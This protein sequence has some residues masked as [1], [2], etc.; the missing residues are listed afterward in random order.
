[1]RFVKLGF[2][3]ILDGADHLLFLFCLVIPFRRL[4]PLI[5]IVTAFTVAHSISLS[6]AVAGF[7]PTGLWFPPLIELLIAA[8]IFYVAIENIVRPDVR[9]RYALW[10]KQPNAKGTYS[11]GTQGKG[12]NFRNDAEDQLPPGFGSRLQLFVVKPACWVA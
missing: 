9:W 6:A 3:H 7:A 8:S 12:A 4:K 11:T 1:M 5:V 2:L 10:E